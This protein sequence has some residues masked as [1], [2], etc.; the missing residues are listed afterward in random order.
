MADDCCIHILVAFMLQ[1]VCASVQG[2]TR[3]SWSFNGQGV[4]IFQWSRSWIGASLLWSSSRMPLKRWTRKT[5]CGGCLFLLEVSCFWLLLHQRSSHFQN[6]IIFFSF[7]FSFSQII[8]ADSPADDNVE[9]SVT[10]ARVA[11]WT[12]KL[13]DEVI[14]L[15][16]NH[17]GSF[18]K[19]KV[20]ILSRQ[21]TWYFFSCSI[22]PSPLSA[23]HCNLTPL[24]NWLF[25]CQL[26]QSRY[27]VIQNSLFKMDDLFKFVTS[28]AR[29]HMP[30]QLCYRRTFFMTLAT[31]FQ[32]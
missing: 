21:H 12:R 27:S 20:I 19:L 17:D 16:R 13:L 28:K 32:H 6:F 18:G 10:K 14:K 23:K 5:Q 30:L 1:L 31:P 3:N 25:S 22:P 26:K 11:A 2:V 7:S 29:Q 15:D 4:E 9:I 8:Y 24:S